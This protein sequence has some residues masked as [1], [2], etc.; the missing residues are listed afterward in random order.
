MIHVY[1][2]ILGIQII[3]VLICLMSI[4]LLLFQRSTQQSKMMLLT[5][6]CAFVQNFGYLL[7]LRA[8][9]LGEVMIALQ[10]EYVGTAYI[11]YFLT[12]FMFRYSNIIRIDL[13]GQSS[14]LYKYRL[15]TDW[16]ISAC[17]TW[18]RTVI[19]HQRFIHLW[20]TCCFLYCFLPFIS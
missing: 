14:V 20:W 16:F 7:E 17:S 9:D 13:S 12:F 10:V 6:V 2:V 4:I 5:I 15:C 1:Q 8:T 3:A 19:Y 11:A 18:K